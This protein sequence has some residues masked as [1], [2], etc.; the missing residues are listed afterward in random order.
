MSEQ[1]TRFLRT[2]FPKVCHRG[3][4]APAWIHPR[5][6]CVRIG[7]RWKRGRERERGIF[8]VFPPLIRHGGPHSPFLARLHHKITILHHA[9]GKK[10]LRRG[11]NSHSWQGKDDEDRRGDCERP[12][13]QKLRLP[14]HR[15]AQGRKYE[16]V[17]NI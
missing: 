15:S 3:V 4:E 11:K 12:R 1:R 13:A 7:S 2:Y 5:R 16:C 9:W 14:K 6:P 8:N 10:G 17:E